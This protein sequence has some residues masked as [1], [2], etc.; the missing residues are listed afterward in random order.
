[1][2]QSRNTK[3]HGFRA[4][5]R[6]RNLLHRRHDY[7][8]FMEWF[9]ARLPY[10]VMSGLIANDIYDILANRFNRGKKGLR[11][12]YSITLFNWEIGLYEKSRKLYKEL[13]EN[14]Q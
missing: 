3:T 7:I 9:Y 12:H 6:N 5:A 2:P 11:D 1:M 8:Q 13:I 4:K 14:G 10:S